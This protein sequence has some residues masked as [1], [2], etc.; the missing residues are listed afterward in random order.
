MERQ[1]RHKP[2]AAVALRASRRLTTID[3]SGVRS[4][5]YATAAA[6]VQLI[7]VDPQ[8]DPERYH[9][10]VPAPTR[11]SRAIHSPQGGHYQPS[12]QTQHASP[13][14]PPVGGL[15]E[16]QRQIPPNPF[17]DVYRAGS[18]A[19]EKQNPFSDD[20]AVLSATVGQGPTPPGPQP[21]EAYHVFS[22]SR[23][24]L[25]IGIVGVAGLFSGLSS[26][27]YF[28]SL[29]AIARASR[30]SVFLLRHGG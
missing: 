6:G 23:K 13:T 20:N 9:D 12:W 21:E 5:L 26:N 22:T 25:L 24:R 28:P 1:D 17:D 15:K 11:Q 16:E 2:R 4:S 14:V 30:A 10:D 19:D 8:Y 7:S 18:P 29:D 3:L 27:I